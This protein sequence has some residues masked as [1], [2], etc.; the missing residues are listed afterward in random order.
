VG[1]FVAGRFRKWASAGT[2][3]S[4]GASAVAPHF[5]WRGGELVEVPAGDQVRTFA[6]NGSERPALAIGG[7]EHLTLPRL[8]P[9]LRD[10]NVYLGAAR[11]ERGART[12]AKVAAMAGRVPGA[13]ATVRWFSALPRSKDGP[14]ETERAKVSSYVTAT[15]YD[16]EGQALRAVRLNCPNPYTFTGKFLAWAAMHAAAAGVSG[17]GAI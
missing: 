4:V 5:A 17:K 8:R 7:L 11:S 10:V 12:A 9:S 15:A 2:R 1:Y 6:V 3:A 16:A 14:D 13:P